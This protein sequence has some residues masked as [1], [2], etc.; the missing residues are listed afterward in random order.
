MI[1]NARNIVDNA[2]QLYQIGTFR[3]NANERFRPGRTNEN[4]PLFAEL[5]FPR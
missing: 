3:H 4:T 1:D 5:F 2:F